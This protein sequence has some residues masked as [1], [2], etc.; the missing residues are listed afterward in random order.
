MRVNNEV[1]SLCHVRLFATPW[2]VARQ[3]PLSMEFYRQE[4]WSGLPCPP[5]GVLLDPKIKPWSL[6]LQVNSLP[7]ESPGNVWWDSNNN[8]TE[9]KALKEQFCGVKHEW[10]LKQRLASDIPISQMFL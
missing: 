7:P 1:K 4:Y 5:P 10:P 6:A 2:A 9:T 3:A 8:G